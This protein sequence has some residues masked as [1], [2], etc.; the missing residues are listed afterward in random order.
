M[1]A[2]HCN[3][4]TPIS[5]RMALHGKP[6][7]SRRR[8]IPIRIRR[9]DSS[10]LYP[11]ASKT[12]ASWL[13]QSSQNALVAE[14]W[15]LPIFSFSNQTKRKLRQIQR[16]A[17][18]KP[19]PPIYTNGY[20]NTRNEISSSRSRLSSQLRSEFSRQPRRSRATQMESSGHQRVRRLYVPSC[21]G[22]TS[23]CQKQ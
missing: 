13:L 21:G 19:Q 11:C 20:P 23:I 22:C 6:S 5:Q 16:A 17:W 2:H 7:Q 3:S 4:Q 18:K 1:E 9:R 8:N 15:R 12:Q 10:H 14:P